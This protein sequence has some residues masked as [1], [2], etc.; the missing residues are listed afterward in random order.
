MAVPITEEEVRTFHDRGYLVL[1]NVF[2]ADELA[3]M[4]S[5]ADRILELLVNSS[6]ATD[7]PSGRLTV[8]GTDRG[9]VVKKVQ[10]VTD[11]SRQFAEIGYDER[12]LGPIRSLLGDEPVLLE[13]KL[14]YK[15]LLPNGA[16]DLAPSAPTDAWPIHNDWAYYRTD[17]YPRSLIWSAVTI[18]DC[19]SDS[20]PIHVWPG[21]H[22][23]HRE[24]EE[25]D[26]A[27]RVR[28]DEV[29]EGG[30]TD[31]DVPAGSVLLFHSLLLHNSAPNRT[32]DPR[33]LLL[34]AHYPQHE[35]DA[36]FD[37]RNGPTRY[38]ESSWEAAYHRL[39][40]TGEF[41]DQFSLRE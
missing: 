33:R 20:G 41:T 2:D 31:L 4:R 34:F 5:E 29:D 32:A 22:V 17:G 6:I 1:R 25:R 40:W 35:F 3:T 30:G 28:Q 38:E 19:P 10:P 15:Q 23:R 14:N 12:F 39:T 16:P 8:A 24:H 13:E 11:L 9:S 18:D 26:G 21:S 37:R 27:L 36:Y 7:R